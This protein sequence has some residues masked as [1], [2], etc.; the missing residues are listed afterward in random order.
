MGRS[1]PSM[2]CMSRCF[3]L[4]ATLSP[5]YGQLKCLHQPSSTCATIVMSSFFWFFQESFGSASLW[6]QLSRQSLSGLCYHTASHR[7]TQK[8][9]Q[10]G[11]LDSLAL[12][13][14]FNPLSRSLV[15]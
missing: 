11:T 5:R 10:R 3:K 14:N 13:Q 6:A 1:V 12:S 8:Q 15:E 7:V 4:S 9:A 2:C